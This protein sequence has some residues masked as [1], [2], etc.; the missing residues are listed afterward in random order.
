ML[1]AMVDGIELMS[2]FLCLQ[3]ISNYFSELGQENHELSFQCAHQINVYT[4]I[5]SSGV[6]K[7]IVF[8]NAVPIQY[9][10]RTQSPQDKTRSSSV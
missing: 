1:S 3:L 10:V 8:N 7:L 2:R 9:D 5:S 4:N 6:D